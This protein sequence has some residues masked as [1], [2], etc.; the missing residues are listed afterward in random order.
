M[1]RMLVFGSAVSLMLAAAGA[2]AQAQGVVQ[3]Q[4]SESS[5]TDNL[6]TVV[7]TGMMGSINRSIG[8]KRNETAIVD[9]VSAEDVGKFP[10]MVRVN[11]SV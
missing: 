9:A 8:I 4:Q 6:A 5:Q 10:E 3:T 7:V 11:M 1:T 2:P